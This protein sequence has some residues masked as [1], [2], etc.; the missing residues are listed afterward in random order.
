MRK[1]TVAEWRAEGERRFGPDERNWKF[2]CP[3]CGTVQG[4]EDF[5][6]EGFARGAGQVNKV[7]GFACIGRWRMAGPHQKGNPP[8]R[9]CDWTLGG[10][11]HIHTLEV[12]DDEGKPHMLFDFAEPEPARAVE[13][14]AAEAAA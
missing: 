1:L 4:A 8:G 9:G 5:Y 2:V 10:L 12:I 13:P 7:L 6:T 11:F 14:K 3:M